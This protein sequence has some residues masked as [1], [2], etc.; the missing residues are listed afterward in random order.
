[1]QGMECGAVQALLRHPA[2][3]E[4]V[5]FLIKPYSRAVPALA[6]PIQELARRLA[7]AASQL[8]FV[9]RCY[10]RLT[11]TDSRAV[12]IQSQNLV[13]V[14]H[15]T[16]SLSFSLHSHHGMPVLIQY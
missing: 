5:H 6:M 3:V 9:Q 2:L 14:L 16:A 12:R 15:S 7:S 4:A 8:C 13:Q 10:T 11:L 1:M